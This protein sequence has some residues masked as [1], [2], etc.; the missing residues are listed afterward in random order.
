[1]K[2]VMY[3]QS[4]VGKLGIA[5]QE[6]AITNLFF[7]NAREPEGCVRTRSPLLE[8]AVRQLKEYFLG[9]RRR[10][11]LPLNPAGTAFQKQAWAAL[12]QIPYGETRTY[13]EIART[14]GNPAACRAVGMANN[15]NPIVIVIPCHRV[16][17]AK[18]DL[19][20]FGGGLSV[21][22]Y[23]LDLEMGRRSL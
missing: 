22:Q 5:E 10:F 7:E 4:P 12:R 15:R 1:M 23:L 13:G 21:K 20:G 2:C 18:G 9:E 16:L 14:I 11:E 8:Q 6:G 17:G 19:V 3:Y